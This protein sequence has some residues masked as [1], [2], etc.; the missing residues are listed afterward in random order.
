M[1]MIS[2]GRTA[3]DRDLIFKL[4][5]EIKEMF[6]TMQGQRITVGQL[7][8]TILR[9]MNNNN[10]GNN[11]NNNN[12]LN[13]VSMSEVEAAV[14]ELQEEEVIQY[15]ERTQTIIIKNSQE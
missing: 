14:K 11:N 5:Q 13:T 9:N 4:I 7:R 6:K 10:F 1:D 3:V 2:T 8:Q 15:I 12:S